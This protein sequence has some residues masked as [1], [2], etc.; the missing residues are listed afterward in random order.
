MGDFH[1]RLIEARES[2]Q[3]NKSQLSK[4]CGVTKAGLSLLEAGK[5][6]PSYK[7]LIKLADALGVTC[8]WLAGRDTNNTNT[9]IFRSLNK[10]DKDIVI[11]II[12][13]LGNKK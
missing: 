8:D 2:Q 12:D 10:K 1:S 11:R 5:R 13:R 4:L 6:E 3:L 9:P 7:V